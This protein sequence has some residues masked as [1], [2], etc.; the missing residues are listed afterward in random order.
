ML[1]LLAGGVWAQQ[2][3]QL[4]VSATIPPPPCQF[5]ETCEPVAQGTTSKVTVNDENV[6]YVG[7]TPTVS[8]EGNLL[9]INF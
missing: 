8:R 5:P 1:A 2:S 4:T 7:S 6:H 3:Q 9:I